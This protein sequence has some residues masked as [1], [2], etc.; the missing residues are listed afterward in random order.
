MQFLDVTN[1]VRFSTIIYKKRVFNNYLLLNWI[2]TTS[3]VELNLTGAMENPSPL[4]T[5]SN[6]LSNQKSPRTYFVSKSVGER[7][8]NGN[9]IV[10]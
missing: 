10:I 8:M 2:I 3:G 6:V 4:H 9:K 5:T 7:F 1:A